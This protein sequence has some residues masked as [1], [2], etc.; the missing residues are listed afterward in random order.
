MGAAQNLFARTGAY[1]TA[2]A[3]LDMFT[4]QLAAEL[5]GAGIAVTAV[6]PGIVD[7]AMPARIRAQ[8]EEAVGAA[9]AHWFRQLHAEVALLP[10]EEPARLIA[11][12]V[13]SVDPSLSGRI[14]DIGS[15]EG[16]RLLPEEAAA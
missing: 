16:Q 5:A 4:S 9:T 6:Y 11:A 3:G 8:P 7:T 14:V 13:G 12:I 15:E 2:K 10:P 1:S